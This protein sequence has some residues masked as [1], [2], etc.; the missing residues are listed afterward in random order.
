MSIYRKYILKR[1]IIYVKGGSA[2]KVS[3]DVE[4]NPSRMKNIGDTFIFLLM[5]YYS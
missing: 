4:W 2:L 3:I 5:T 1:E